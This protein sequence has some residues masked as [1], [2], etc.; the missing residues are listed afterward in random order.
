[1]PDFLSLEDV[2]LLHGNQ[3][4]LYGGSHGVRDLNLLESAIAQPQATFGSDL[5]HGDLFE[6]AATYLFHIVKNHPFVDG[7]K[8]TGVVAALAFLDLNGV[9]IDAPK[10]GIHD[11]AM[12]VATGR[13]GKTEV[14]A[15]F[16]KHSH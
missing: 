7:N 5:L 16:R 12:S 2:L 3:V 4:D 8:R 11:L 15:F 1:M 14:A 6:M 13:A 9:E 10:G